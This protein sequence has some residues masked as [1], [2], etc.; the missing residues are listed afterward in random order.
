MPKYNSVTIKN[1]FYLTLG[2]FLTAIA[3]NVFLTPAS[4]AP[5]GASGIATVLY[6]S[7]NIPMYFTV[8]AVNAVL[9]LL[10]YKNLGKR[11]LF[12]TIYATVIMSFFIRLTENLGKIDNDFV[13]SAVM[14]GAL[15]G[16]GT[17][18]TVAG[19]GSTGGTD[20]A[21]ILLNNLFGTITI[22]KLIMIIDFFVIVL[23]GIVFKNYQIMLYSAIS[24]Y[25][26]AKIADNIIEGVNF[27]VLV[28]II[29]DRGGQI[30][31]ALLN[32][33]HHGVT[34]IESKGMYSNCSRSVLMCAVRRNEFVR[35]KQI[36]TNTDKNAFI[37]LTDARNV[38]GEGFGDK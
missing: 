36:V 29:T 20:L 24:L 6:K 14:G 13:L 26:S 2:A 11:V 22:A 3:L 7:A 4:L 12:K 38:L 1:Y 23:S 27:A 9:L 15:M 31:Q 35:L 17:G 10:G 33:L 30:G 21:A 25:I 32:K 19:G 18:L 37:I 8:L 16:A 28:F 5:G 34:S